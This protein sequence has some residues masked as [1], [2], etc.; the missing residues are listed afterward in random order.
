MNDRDKAVMHRSCYVR[1]RPPGFA[2]DPA[3]ECRIGTAA[4]ARSQKRISSP[5]LDRID[6]HLEV[7]RIDEG[8]LAIAAPRTP[9]R[10]SGGGVRG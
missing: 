10:R 7:R 5:L 1:G 6:I 9:R 2:G 3:R 8:Q 4:I